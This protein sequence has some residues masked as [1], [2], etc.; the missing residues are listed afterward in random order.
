MLNVEYGDKIISVESE[1]NPMF[2][3][4]ARALHGKWNKPAWEFDASMKDAVRKALMDCYGDDGMSKYVKVR[5]DLDACCCLDYGESMYLSGK[6]LIATRFS[7]D[8]AVK[9]PDNVFCVDGCFLDSGGSVKHPCVTWEDG[10][11]VEMNIP[12]AVYDECKDDEGI[13]LVDDNAEKRTALEE[14]KKKLMQRIEE[15][16]KELANL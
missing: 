6:C 15:I 16:D 5:I 3:R 14:E 1:Y 4:K 2:V 10:T 8:S 7:R 12:Q 11:V 13:V 9:L